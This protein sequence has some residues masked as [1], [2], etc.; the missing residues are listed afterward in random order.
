MILAA[1]ATAAALDSRVAAFIAGY[2]LVLSLLAPILATHSDRIS[3]GFGRKSTS[4]PDVIP[5][6]GI[7]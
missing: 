5:T 7:A 6:G 4:S 3:R 1:R 2:V